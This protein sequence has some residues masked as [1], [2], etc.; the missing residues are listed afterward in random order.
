MIHN[1]I[2]NPRI[3]RI[4]LRRILFIRISVLPYSPATGWLVDY[5]AIEGEPVVLLRVRLALLF[6]W[7]FITRENIFHKKKENKKN[8]RKYFISFI[9]KQLSICIR[10]ENGRQCFLFLNFY[11]FF[12]PFEFV[13]LIFYCLHNNGKCRNKDHLINNLTDSMMT[14]LRYEIYVR[15]AVPGLIPSPPLKV[16]NIK[17][18]FNPLRR[19]TQPSVSIPHNSKRI[20]PHDFLVCCGVC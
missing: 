16:F 15:R 18:E 1:T 11:L 13:S 4:S 8:L 3:P 5:M 9:S 12:Y 6:F 19:A 17:F 7:S 2:P 14:K 20:T 10:H